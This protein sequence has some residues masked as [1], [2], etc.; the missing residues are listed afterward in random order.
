MNGPIPEMEKVHRRKVRQ[1]KSH[2]NKV[3]KG[4]AKSANYKAI[5][6]L[7]LFYNRRLT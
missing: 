6:L 7:R 5:D 1:W 4:R 2:L 3:L